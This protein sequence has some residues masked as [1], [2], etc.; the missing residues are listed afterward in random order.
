[1]I[2]NISLK[3]IATYD[4]NGIAMEELKKIN[5][6]YGNNGT[7]KTTL[8][9]YLRM[10]ETETFSE[11]M[12]D[13]D[14]RELKVCVFNRKFVNENFEED[15]SI[16][17]I[18]T[19]GKESVELQTQISELRV[20]IKQHEESERGLS[21]NISERKIEINKIIETFRQSCW[22]IKLSIDKLNLKETIEGYR[23]SRDNFMKKYLEEAE[24]NNY[25]IQT[26][27]ELKER[28]QSLYELNDEMVK[29]HDIVP[30][31]ESNLEEN[32]I[33]QT[34]II[35]KEDV[36]ISELITKLQI[37]DWVKQGQIISKDTEGICPF[38]QQTFSESFE[39][40]L[41]LYFD[42][43]YT[44]N[45]QK[46]ESISDDYIESMTRVISKIESL[47][48]VVMEKFIDKNK[49]EHNFLLIK[50]KFEENQLLINN[51]LKEPSR[52]IEL[53]KI[54]GL[55]KEINQ[56]IAESNLKIDEHNKLISARI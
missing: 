36:D 24:N 54:S 34:K 3:N 27:E 13:W 40:K 49:I 26:L 8:S 16:K 47:V 19:L 56:I 38:C 45:I 21:D 55:I 46:L 50:S 44:D 2:K 30:M 32:Q 28:Y 4:H 9:E 48:S 23:N 14:D 37:S 41:N 42:Q 15:N 18:F 39:E 51:K 10:P 1:M 7:G 35:G 22:E 17:G 5:F 12:T 11:C 53:V 33:F 43:T 20:K 31:I 52:V 6:I 29:K 25:E